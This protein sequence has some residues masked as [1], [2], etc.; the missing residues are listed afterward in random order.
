MSAEVLSF[1]SDVFARWRLRCPAEAEAD[2]DPRV[3]FGEG[4]PCRE[5][6]TTFGWRGYDG[7]CGWCYEEQNGG[8]A[9]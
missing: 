8:W 5:C 6:S 7:L 1:P 3:R 2:P 9:A 4:G